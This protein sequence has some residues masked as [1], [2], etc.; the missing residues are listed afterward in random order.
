MQVAALA[1]AML[2]V[3]VAVFQIGLAAGAP[4]GDMA[5]GGRADTHNGV[6]A[7]PYRITSALAVAVLALAAWIVL[8]RGD[9]L[10]GEPMSTGF[11]EAGAWVVFGY[12]VLNTAANLASTSKNERLIM[13]PVTAV[14][15]V[16]VLIV[17]LG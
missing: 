1:G 4:W 9:V 15:A 12:L 14:A 11:I 3:G 17:A 10:S 13:G 6:L 7:L 2:L 5:Y 8:A 16:F